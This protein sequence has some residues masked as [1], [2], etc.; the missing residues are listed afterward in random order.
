MDNEK[1]Q[2]LKKIDEYKKLISELNEKN[3]F[4]N[5][6]K[7]CKEAAQY[8]RKIQIIKQEEENNVQEIIDKIKE[9]YDK[10]ER[11]LAA[12]EFME[13]WCYLFSIMLKRIFKEDS[14][15]YICS[16]SDIHSII[17]I[18]DSFYDVRGNITR[19]VDLS[20]YYKPTEEDFLY[21]IDICNIGKSKIIIEKQEKRCDEIVER[22]LE[23]YNNNSEEISQNSRKI[24]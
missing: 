11:G 2:Y 23:E 17:K 15:I 16:N 22:I 7:Y 6:K 20:N 12:T 9:E 1:S 13:N 3:D 10:N 8:L 18:Y 4:E 21:F 5:V 19:K 24:S 14:S